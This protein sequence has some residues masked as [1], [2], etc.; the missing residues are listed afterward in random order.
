MRSIAAMQ[1]YSVDIPVWTAAYNYAL[2]QDPGDVDGANA[3]A[4][5]DRVVRMSQS[6]GGAKDLAAIQRSRGI[7][8][9][10]T[11][12][13]SFFSA[14]YGIL[15]SVGKEFGQGV[16]R[17]PVGASMKAATRI[18]ILITLQEAASAFIKGKLPE[19]EPD[20]EEDESLGEFLAT[21]TAAGL[22]SGIPLV[23]DVAVGVVSDYGYGGSPAGMFGEA[24]EKLLKKAA[25]KLEDGDETSWIDVAKPAV[26]VGAVATGKVPA[27]Q[28]NRFID[29]LEALYEEQPGWEWHDLLSGYDADIAAKRD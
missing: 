9:A 20:D 5:A 29:G 18:F 27:I 17:N 4:Y 24:V 22:F 10:A 7:T 3:V 6:G 1:L 23:R 14:L 26:I 12:F 15:R 21:R 25:R 2:Q 8:K 28:V 13:Y 19:W 16:V 11:M